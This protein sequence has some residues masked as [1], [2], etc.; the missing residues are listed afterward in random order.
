[1]VERSLLFFVGIVR[2][3]TFVQEISIFGNTNILLSKP[4]KKN[5]DACNFSLRA[6]KN[7]TDEQ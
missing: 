7:K 4:T 1:M 6:I 2:N 5:N 3:R